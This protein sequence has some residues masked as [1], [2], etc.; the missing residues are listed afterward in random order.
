[1]GESVRPT[2]IEHSCLKE[3]TAKSPDKRGFPRDKADMTAH[4]SFGTEISAEY[5]ILRCGESWHG[6]RERA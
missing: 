5:V 6:T 2:G 3:Y 4:N 1:M